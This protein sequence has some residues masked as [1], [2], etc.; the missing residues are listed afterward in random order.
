MPLAGPNLKRP[1]PIGNLLGHGLKT[2]PDDVALASARTQMSWRQLDELIRF[3]RKRVGYKAPE[4]IVI[5]DTMPLNVTGKVDRMILK[6][7]PKNIW[8]QQPEVKA[9]PLGRRAQR[10][11]EPM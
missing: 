5:L 6:Q 9:W 7:M 11:P 10:E 4:E 3:A 8:R 1:N 2:K